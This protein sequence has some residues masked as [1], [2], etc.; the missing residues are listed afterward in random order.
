MDERKNT[1]LKKIQDAHKIINQA[2]DTFKS[3]QLAITWTGGKDSTLTLWLIRQVCE[4][5]GVALPGCMIIDEGDPFREIETF[6]DQ[7]K[8]EWGIDLEVCRNDD[9]I[10]AAGGK[11]GAFVKVDSLNA[12]NRAEIKR[13]G[14]EEDEFPFEAES[15]VGN[16]LM[17][18]VMFNQ[19]IEDNNIKGIFQGIRW[20][21]HPARVN[22]KYFMKKETDGELNPEHTRICPILHFTERD[23]WDTTLTHKIPFNGLYKKGY[24]SLGA[25][26]T[27]KIAMEDVPAWNQDLEN[28][29]ERDGRR[30]D[31][32]EAMEKLRQL[33]YM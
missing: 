14:Y 26:S 18:T 11:L 30:Q 9:V 17:K 31:K 25:A 3:E 22:D 1:V 33:G 5:R 15:F 29:G 13:I 2:F 4:D 21:E 32:E 7:Y 27:S 20:D 10:E 24:R 12:R 28:T 6:V 8:S 19:F 16:H 23:V